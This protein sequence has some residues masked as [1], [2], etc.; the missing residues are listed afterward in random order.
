[1][2]NF[3]KDLNLYAVDLTPQE[4]NH[5]K[6]IEL[7]VDS[8]D[9]IDKSLQNDK[10][11]IFKV[12][13]PTTSYFDASFN[14]FD[15]TEKA[16]GPSTLRTLENILN[17]SKNEIKKT[18]K[19]PAKKGF[20]LRSILFK[21]PVNPELE[22]AIKED[23]DYIKW[24]LGPNFE[25]LTNKEF[26][27]RM[28]DINK[29]HLFPQEGFVFDE[30]GVKKVYI[31]NTED[32]SKNYAKST[33]ILSIKQPKIEGPKNSLVN[34]ERF[35]E[36]FGAKMYNES[37]VEVSIKELVQNSF[38]SL[39]SDKKD[40]AKIVVSLDP[41]S[42]KITVSDNGVGMNKKIMEEAF[43]KIAG[44]DKS[45]LT[46]EQ[47]SGGFGVA[48]MAF[49]FGNEKIMVRSVK[50]G[51]LTSFVGDSQKLLNNNIEI[52][53]SPT[54]ELNGTMVEIVV[55]AI[56]LN[57]SSRLSVVDFPKSLNDI[58]FLKNP[59][60][61][62]VEVV[63]QISGKK[64]ILKIG[65]HDKTTPPPFCEVRF[66]WGRVEISMEKTSKDFV[67]RSS[68]FSSGLHQFEKSIRKGDIASDFVK[69]KA[70]INVFSSVDVT[71]KNY[72]FSKEREGWS[73]HVEADILILNKIVCALEKQ[74]DREVLQ[75]SHSS[76]YKIEEGK[77]IPKEI[78]I[79]Q[80]DSIAKGEVIYVKNGEI[81]KSQGELFKAGLKVD[82]TDELIYHQGLPIRENVAKSKNVSV[83]SFDAAII[84]LA[85]VMKE[86]KKDLS[87]VPGYEDIVHVKTG[88]S[89]DEGYHGAYI[90]TPFEALYLNP[91]T[92]DAKPN[93]LAHS[94][95][96]ILVH[97]A[98]HFKQMN[99]TEKFTTEM[100]NLYENLEEFRPGSYQN[101]IKN[102][103]TV[104]ERHENTF[105]EINALY[106]K[107]KVKNRESDFLK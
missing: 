23:Q 24:A 15:L 78:I 75:K 105:S 52:R 3:I 83:A 99:H 96:H 12:F 43:L 93:V 46:M 19:E 64:E 62:P 47:R 44:S 2:D 26:Y 72:P 41:K 74:L 14:L 25:K 82:K 56:S 48:K 60:L 13:I 87:H 102:L 73:K 61:G 34:F 4:T 18:F 7:F 29:T 31:K 71:S 88:I 20:S 6:C 42:R 9:A 5:G 22:K 8:A 37:I 95:A 1:M 39:K 66:S 40:N 53:E 84:D 77:L 89:I 92:K 21:E 63:G 79:D 11:S 36:L 100:G 33:D 103:Q 51:V 86:F 65:K 49:L 90:K 38:D 16:Y 106:L 101:L 35:I 55:P 80:V 107:E 67:A 81:E 50:D 17:N 28:K 59:L 58:E 94:W 97:E 27:D 57:K 54:T 85:N 10:S 69:R 76:Y 45:G 98:V 30:N 91:A 70:F 104:V 68:V 32:F